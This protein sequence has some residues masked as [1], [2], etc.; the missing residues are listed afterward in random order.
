MIRSA[1]KSEGNRYAISTPN[2]RCTKNPLEAA[3][4]A[5]TAAAADAS[6]PAPFFFPL[7]L[8]LPS[9]FFPKSAQLLPAGRQR[10]RN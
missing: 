7:S 3:L 4:Q 6:G 1:G 2:A 5:K 10:A 9:S 8:S